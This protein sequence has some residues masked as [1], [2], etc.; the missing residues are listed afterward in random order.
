MAIQTTRWQPDT[1]ACDLSYTW[2]D[3]TDAST[4]VH[5]GSVINAACPD[6]AAVTDPAAH[7]GVVLGENQRKN[8]FLD[9]ALTTAAATLADTKTS[10][11][12]GTTTTLKETVEYTFSFNASRV[13]SV[14]FKGVASK[15]SVISVAEKTA[16]QTAADVKFG[17]G[18]V[19]V[20]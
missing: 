8:Q 20:T 18:K 19:S 3:K 12:T 4:R 5:T 13:M 11:R 10:P 6:H 2:D 9:V 16:L 1:C 14:S 7:F 17:A 15:T